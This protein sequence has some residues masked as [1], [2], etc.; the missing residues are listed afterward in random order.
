M[1][2]K[3]GHTSQ[4]VGKKQNI[5]IHFLIKVGTPSP[6]KDRRKL[7]SIIPPQLNNS[8]LLTFQDTNKE[9]TYKKGPAM[10]VE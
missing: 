10:E 1:K 7:R 6:P 3:E 8:C 2:E 9:I 4:Q 5:S